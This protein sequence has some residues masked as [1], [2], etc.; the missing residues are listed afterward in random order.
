MIT[1]SMIVKNEEKYLADCLASVQDIVDE[2]VLVDTGSTDKTIDIAKEYDAKIFNFNWVNDFSAARNYALDK[3]SGDW[4]LYLDADE[5]LSPDSKA[6]L[7][8]LTKEIKKEAY[9]CIVD[10]IDEIGH[11]AALMA[12]PRLFPN[13]N[14]LRFE[15]AIHE[16]IEPALLKNHYQIKNAKIKIIHLG[17][18][19]EKAEMDLKAKRNLEILMAE[20]HRTKS[21]YYAFQLGQ[22]YGLLNKP[23]EAVFYFKECLKDTNLN[24][25]FISTAYRYIAVDSAKK[26]DY[27]KAIELINKSLAADAEQPLAL[28]AASSIYALINDFG[29]ADSYCREAYLVNNKLISQKK[30]SSQIPLS[31]DKSIL[32][33]GLS[34]SIQAKDKNLYNYYSGLINNSKTIKGLNDLQNLFSDLLNNKKINVPNLEKYVGVIDDSNINILLSVLKDYQDIE[35]ELKLL[36]KIHEKFS[37]NY[38]FLNSYGLVLSESK[39]QEESEIIFEKS[40][41]LNP[42]EPSTIFYLISSYIQKNQNGK[43]IDIIKEAEE[44]FKEHPGI[45][46]QIELLKAKLVN[47]VSN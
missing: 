7:R 9:Y 24:K 10:N 6:E 27:K 19:V 46:N 14:E 38:T 5:R 33:H 18:N 34:I 42:Y 13:K 26:R 11:R 29:K 30:Y 43:I 21:S 36:N 44:R 4:V 2:I 15:G 16:Q 23:E 1:L 22:T 3:S 45:S 40:Y 20:Y 47:Y 35:S 39:L 28:L 25:D 12:Y 31:D 37:E 41:K 17:Y 8:S 32:Y